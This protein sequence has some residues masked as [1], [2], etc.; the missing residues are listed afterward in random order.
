[1]EKRKNPYYLPPGARFANKVEQSMTD[2][3]D[4]QNAPGLILG[5]ALSILMIS[6]FNQLPRLMPVQATNQQPEAKHINQPKFQNPHHSY[7]FYKRYFRRRDTD[8]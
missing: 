6:G 7:P 8:K 2:L 4:P 1:M 3:A 5:L